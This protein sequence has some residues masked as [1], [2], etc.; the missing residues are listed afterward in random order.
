[1]SKDYCIYSSSNPKLF[2]P[3]STDEYENL[4]KAKFML[5]QYLYIEEKLNFFI[6]N[7]LE[8]EKEIINISISN[9]LTPLGTMDWTQ[10]VTEIHKINLRII[11]LLTTSRMYLDHVSHDL[12]KVCEDKRDVVFVFEK[13]KN[14]EYDNVLGYRVMEALRNYVQHRGLP[15]HAIAHNVNKTDEIN[16]HLIIPVLRISDLETDGKFKS[17]VLKELK[18]LGDKVDLRLYI[19]QYVQSFYKLQKFIRDILAEDILGFDDLITRTYSNFEKNHGEV[20]SS[21]AIAELR[22]E[23]FHNDIIYIMKDIIIRRKW[24]ERK[25]SLEIDLTKN[26]VTGELS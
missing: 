26:F 16:K 18:Q 4:K 6:D 14:S 10:N 25:N 3:I 23:K 24:L 19:R 7:Y 8:L 20:S 13:L 9:L 17:S 22:L 5:Q 12:E 11:N 2:D 1:M 21:L 15:I